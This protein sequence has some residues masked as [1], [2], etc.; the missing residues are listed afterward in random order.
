MES[1][2]LVKVVWDAMCSAPASV[3]DALRTPALATV[4]QSGGPQVRTVVLREAS[5]PTKSLTFF[6]DTRSPK[7]LQLK[8]SPDVQLLCWCP[9]RKWQLRI[10]AQAETTQVGSRVD[11]F[12]KTIQSTAQASDYMSLLPPGTE[13]ASVTPDQIDGHYLGIVDLY[14][15]EIDFLMLSREGH[16]RFRITGE[17]VV[18]LTP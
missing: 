4:D 2:N 18:E 16:K 14:V 7:W 12:W 3:G 10:S 6:T 9:E 11:A 15:E 8:D 13:L 1:N 17:Q 5:R